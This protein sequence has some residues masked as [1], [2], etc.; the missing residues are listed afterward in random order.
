MDDE[1]LKNSGTKLTK[2]YFEKLLI[3]IQLDYQREDSIKK[4]QI[5]M[6]YP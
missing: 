1:R 5:F 4:L 3:K 2:D 6:S